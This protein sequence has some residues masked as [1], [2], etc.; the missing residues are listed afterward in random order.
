MLATSVTPVLADEEDR[1]AETEYSEPILTDYGMNGSDITTEV[2]YVISGESGE[3]Y[4]SADDIAISEFDGKQYYCGGTVGYGT[5][6]LTDQEIFNVYMSVLYDHPLL[7]FM[8]NSIVYDG[9][10]LYLLV[11]DSFASGNTRQTYA[12]KIKSA[13]KDFDEVTKDC[14]SNYS[15]AKNVHDTIINQVDYAFSEDGVTPKDNIY[16][17][18]IT[19][20][21][22]EEKEVVCDGY[23]KTYQAVMNYLDIDTIFV[24]GWGV[25]QGSETS[26][27]TAHAWNMVKLGDGSYYF[28]DV[29]WDDASDAGI[30]TDYF[31][32]GNELYR[33]HSTLKTDTSESNYFLYDLP[34]VGY[35]AFS[36]EDI[37]AK[38]KDP[39]YIIMNTV[40]YD[41]KDGVM[42][43]T[44]KGGIFQ[45][46]EYVDGE[47]YQYK[48][49]VT[50][51]VFN[52]GITVIGN[53][54]FR[55]F[56]QVTEISFP[57]GLKRIGQ[58]AFYGCSSL[59]EVVLPDEISFF[60]SE[61][62]GSCAG[63]KKITFGEWT[64]GGIFIYADV[65]MFSYSKNLDTIIVPEGHG[66]FASI[67]N[68]LI[69]KNTGTVIAYAAGKK[70]TVYEIPD[71]I[72]IIGDS[73]FEDCGYLQEVIIPDSVGIVGSSAFQDCDSLISLSFPASVKQ[74]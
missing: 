70:D 69:D 74:F 25:G 7:Y 20:Y 58:Q 66:V 9:V 49:Q 23:A 27:A 4:E 50:R 28:V 14:D 6:G 48:D 19:G 44:G 17:H 37:L 64:Q 8:N 56:D 68:V 67:D 62:F 45:P 53:Y 60:D 11:G 12:D 54:T 26:D 46:E 29:T 18:N 3:T 24:N 15:I 57:D 38:E 71:S 39:E 2:E 51:L 72:Q 40:N 42:T 1:L 43:F 73:A 31:C 5:L 21:V 65:N 32:I 59:T 33:D 13:I 63:L 61:I 36:G 52:E 30:I 35:P 16:V 41:V 55:N 47:W 34:D 22:A 10:D